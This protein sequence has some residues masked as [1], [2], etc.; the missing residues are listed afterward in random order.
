MLTLLK[1]SLVLSLEPQV[2][3]LPVHGQIL[4]A[5]LQRNVPTIWY[6]NDNNDTHHEVTFVF[7]WT[8]RRP[9]DGGI[10]IATMQDA[11]ELVWHLF[12]MPKENI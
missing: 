4:A 9:P 12:R 11:D 2:I 7:A 6:V 10:H 3:R 5:Q 1:Q 8:G